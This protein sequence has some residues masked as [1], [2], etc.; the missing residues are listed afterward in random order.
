MRLGI[1]IGGTKLQLVVGDAAGKIVLRR[2]LA[3]DAA[4]G[5]AG[6][7]LLIERALPEL[8][9]GAQ[10]GGVGVGFGGPVDWKTG[11]ICRSHQIEGWAEF[12]LGGWLGQLAEAPVVV[13]NDANVG[14]LG[15]AVR[16]A[17]VGFNPVFY[18]TLGSG[19]GGGLVVDGK[20]YHGAKPGE[21]E[22]GH[23]RLDRDGTIVESRCSGWAVDARIRGLKAKEPGSLL[24]R[25]TGQRVGGEA[26][27][28]AAAWQ[29]GDA[30][31]RRLLQETAEDLAFG[32]S[33]VVH[34]FHPEMIVPGR[35]LVGGGRA[36]ARVSR[37]RLAV[38]CHGG[39]RPGAENCVGRAWRGCRAGG[40]TRI[41]LTKR[42]G[43][44]MIHAMK[45]WIGDYINAQKAAHDSIPAEARG[46]AD[47]EAARGAQ[48]RPADSRVRHRRERRQRVPFRD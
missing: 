31:A 22:I 33:H 35:G 37:G 4:T 27:H 40:R 34:L 26:K 14:A 11:R 41:G 7:R 17:G 16:G 38:F 28:L 20:I 42:T 3:V 12:D 18:V 45:Q 32:L 9:E 15:E 29:Q 23:V 2:R 36:V 6:I 46:A 13:D 21:A 39:F 43:R 1:E 30:A 47:P 24:G 19:V 10:I 44:R 5:A 8:L 25:L 48:G